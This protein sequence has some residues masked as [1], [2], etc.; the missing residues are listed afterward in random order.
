MNEA[1]PPNLEALRYWLALLH[2][3][4]VGASTFNRLLGQFPDPRELFE[5]GSSGLKL[6]PSLQAYLQKPDW[7]AVDRDLAW[8]TEPGHHIITCNDGCYPAL[9]TQI[10]DIPPLLFVHGNPSYLDS[11][12]IAMVGSRNP[13]ASGRQTASDFASF[14]ASAGITI[15]SG[16]ATGIDGTAHKGALD[17]GG[18]SIAVTGTGLDLIYPARHKALAHRIVEQGALVS[19]FPVGTPPLPGH[20]PRRNR[21]ISALSM[22]TLVVEAAQRSGSLITARHAI[23]QGRE[24]FAIPGSIH[25]PLSRGCHNLIR[26]GAKLVETAAD[27]IEELRPLLGSLEMTNAGESVTPAQETDNWD[28]DYQHLLDNMG[29]DPVT[30][31]QLIQRSGFTAEAVCSMLLLLELEGHVSSVAGGKFI[32]MGKAI[33]TVKGLSENRS[34]SE[35]K[36]I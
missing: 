28:E 11:P 13:S 30:V 21:I 29:Y 19:E 15:T 16:L 7:K 17:V 25:N 35:G 23:E 10:T 36:L 3:P 4:G 22:G 8:A 32:R 14:L 27:I 34:R 1:L 5:N 20:F 2:A 31:D 26:Q 9:L 24:V 12:Q 33:T 6:K 18:K